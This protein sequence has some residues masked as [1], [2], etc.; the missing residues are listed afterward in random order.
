M[1]KSSNSRIVRNISLRIFLL[2][3]ICAV[4]VTAGY[5]QKKDTLNSNRVPHPN[6]VK[7]SLTS[8][9]L[10]ANS[11]HMG[12]ERVL[13][14]HQSISIFGGYNEFPVNLKLNLSG[15]SLKGESSKSGYLI[16]AQYRFYLP[17]ENKYDAPHGLYLAPY[18]SYYNFSSNRSISHTDSA[19]Y[20]QT[21]G[22]TT[23]IGLFNIG[24]ML[25]YQFVVFK[26]FVID[27]ELLGPSY[28]FYSFKASIKGQL[29]GVDPDGTAAAIIEALKE[30]FPLLND[31]GS[32]QE[33]SRSGSGVAQS[34]FSFIGFRYSVSIGFMF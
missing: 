34:K 2:A 12:Y 28:T 26:R 14:K 13:G 20:T 18:M 4:I 11:L 27:A 9:V 16:G 23:D 31:L 29:N 17:L 6:V 1:K 25:G 24:G 30:K 21:A 19:G 7:L 3:S 22:L 8:W 32:G 5:S 10:Y 15:T 33:V